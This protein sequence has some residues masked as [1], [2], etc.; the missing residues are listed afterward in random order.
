MQTYYG[1]FIHSYTDGYLGCFKFLA[2]MNK[3]AMNI[4]VQVFLWA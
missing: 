4:H 3:A 2:V 1:L